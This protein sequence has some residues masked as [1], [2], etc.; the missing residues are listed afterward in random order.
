MNQPKNNAEDNNEIT[1]S[2]AD[3]VDSNC[4][5]E[6]S[7]TFYTQ[8]TVQAALMAVMNYID[9]Q[10]QKGLV[11]PYF[12]GINR[13]SWQSKAKALDVYITDAIESRALNLQARGKDYAT[14]ILSY[15]SEIPASI[16]ELMPTIALGE[17]IICHEVVVTEA[18]E[19]GKGVAQHISHLLVHGLLHLLGFDHEIGQAEQEEMERFEIDIL[20]TMD[21]ANPYD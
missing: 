19:Q 14:N 7:N 15:P 12:I 5:T 17:L 9:A 20:A 2:I 10:L 4:N 18:A 21:L 11:L 13:D 6:L 16:I 3:N 1:I 8:K